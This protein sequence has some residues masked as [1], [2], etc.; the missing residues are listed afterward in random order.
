MNIVCVAACTAGI[1]HTYIAR[2]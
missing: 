1:A 2:E